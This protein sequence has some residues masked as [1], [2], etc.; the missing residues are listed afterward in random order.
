MIIVSIDS[1]G[2]G[3]RASSWY[4]ASMKKENSA[5]SPS[6]DQGVNLEQLHA[7]RE[8]LLNLHKILMDIEREGYER[9]FGKISSTSQFLQLMLQDP[10]FAWLRPLSHLVA[11]IDEGLDSKEPLEKAVAD[12]LLQDTRKLLTPS[13]EGAG[14]S[15]NYY[16]ALQEEPDVVMAHAAVVKNLP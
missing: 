12:Q 6:S 15:K 7:L 8:G 5:K 10:W 13:E 11:M 3:E 14:F 9:V 2:L 16:D 4:A 1:I